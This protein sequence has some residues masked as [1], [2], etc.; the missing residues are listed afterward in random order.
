[1]DKKELYTKT[2][3][4]LFIQNDLLWE[5][6]LR[7]IDI[8]GK[9]PE[10]PLEEALGEAGIKN[11]LAEQLYGNAVEMDK[12]RET[13]MNDETLMDYIFPKMSDD[14]IDDMFNSI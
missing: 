10:M 12:I 9:N 14:D 7:L 11:G 5:Y 13:V 4:L 6:V 1:M 8:S 2:I 3:N